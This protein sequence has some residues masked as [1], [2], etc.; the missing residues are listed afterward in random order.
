MIKI[1]EE[2]YVSVGHMFD[3]LLENG[4]MLHENEFNGEVYTVKE[5][6]VE[7]T[8]RPVYDEHENENGGF[9]IIGFEN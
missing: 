1:K 5:N 7:T 6:G 9:D 4:V 8:Y 3:Y 2:N